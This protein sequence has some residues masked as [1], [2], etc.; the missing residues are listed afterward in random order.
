[1]KFSPNGGAIVVGVVETA[2]EITVWVRDPGIGVRGP[3]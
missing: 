1:V 2:D 3:I